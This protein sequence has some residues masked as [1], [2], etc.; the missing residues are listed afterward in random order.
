M[1]GQMPLS[2]FMVTDQDSTP[3]AYCASCIEYVI[4]DNNYH[5]CLACDFLMCLACEADGVDCNRDHI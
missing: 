2:D 1:R 3:Y 5:I 4:A